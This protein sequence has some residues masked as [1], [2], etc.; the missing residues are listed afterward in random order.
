MENP[1]NPLPDFMIDMELLQDLY[2]AV[3]RAEQRESGPIMI[4]ATVV[5]V[6]VVV[7]KKAGAT[8]KD[9]KESVSIGWAGL[10]EE[11]HEPRKQTG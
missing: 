4:F 3:Q 8:L 9:V 11:S 6:A 5:G 1:Q 7:A 10:R 2:A